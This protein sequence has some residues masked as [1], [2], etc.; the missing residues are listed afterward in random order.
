MDPSILGELK[1]AVIRQQLGVYGAHL[2][3]EGKG[4]VQCRFRS[5]ERTHLFS[6]SKTFTA[7][8]VGIAQGEGRLK[9]SDAAL[10]FFSQWR[11]IAAPGAE[12]ITIR[13]LLHMCAGHNQSLFT[14]LN[15]SQEP[16][17]DWAE[18]FFT[19][20]QHSPAGS[21]FCYDNG[22]TYILS[23]IIQAVSGQS[24][25]DYLMPRLFTPL[26]ITNPQWHTCPQGHCIGAFG[27]Y[28][29]TEE[30]SRLGILMLQD[31]HWQQKPL[32]PSAFIHDA[33][34]DT[35][36]T[37]GFDDIENRQGYGYQLWRCTIPGSYR[38]DGK[39]GQYSV[40][41]PRQRAVITIT[42]HNE[43]CA[44]DILRAVWAHTLP[45]IT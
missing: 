37:R 26:G 34:H 31:G 44:N 19:A 41:L 24:L 21:T 3:V 42:A 23:R 18:L 33:I 22:C 17:R 39:Y 32:V 1:Q 11:D 10:S 14:T 36:T 15:S 16:L 43:G 40:V 8:A 30:F 25:R 7:M 35:V 13:D 4:S 2:Y 5:D 6:G 29:T 45:Q 27:L 9:I 12:R 28:L 38:A 20:S